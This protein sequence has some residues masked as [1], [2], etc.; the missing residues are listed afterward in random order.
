M[1][2][3]WMLLDIVDGD[4]LEWRVGCVNAIDLFN[5][6]EISVDMWWMVI[7][8]ALHELIVSIHERQ[9]NVD[10]IIQTNE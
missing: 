3:T 7:G 1:W 10:W 9:L 6:D 2:S 4:S 5:N 8:N